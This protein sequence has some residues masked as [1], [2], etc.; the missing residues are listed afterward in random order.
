MLR[1]LALGALVLVTASCSSVA[2]DPSGL[3]DKDYRTTYEC[4]P[5]T[6]D[7]IDIVDARSNTTGREIRTPSFWSTSFED[8]IH[9]FLTSNHRDYI[10]S[11]VIS[12]FDEGERVSV[13]V[14]VLRGR[15]LI[16][17]GFFREGREVEFG[18]DIEI[19]KLGAGEAGAT[20][21]GYSVL[22]TQ[23]FGTSPIDFSIMYYMVITEAIADAMRK[24]SKQ[25][26]LGKGKKLDYEG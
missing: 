4:L 17:N 5:R 1:S 20:F 18:C 26:E 9:P 10:Q 7:S 11:R 25:I 3:M 16:D 8:E 6:V 23:D 24:Y 13:R 21:Y 19:R 2:H 14:I 12:Q 22:H 15:M